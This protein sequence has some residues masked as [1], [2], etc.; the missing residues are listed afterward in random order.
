MWC[1]LFGF[2][3]EVGCLLTHLTVKEDGVPQGAVT[4]SFLAN[5]VFWGSEPGLFRELQRRGYQYTRFVDDITVSSK[6]H[7]S[8]KEKSAIIKA[9]YSMLHTAG[10]K[11]KRQKHEV[12]TARSRITTTKLVNNARVSLPSE[13]RQRVRAAV[14][15]LEGR[16]AFGEY[17]DALQKQLASVSS[18]VGRLN[19]F[20]P[21]EGALLKIR[22]KHIRQKIE[23]ISSRGRSAQGVTKIVTT[24]LPEYRQPPWE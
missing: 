8:T 22:L 5:L 14:H 13:V 16:V 21:A 11:P 18:R 4:S 7:L 1:G 19:S 20:H 10:V 2:S 3:D 15:Q 24:M 17:D 23:E 9:V 12:H 6:H